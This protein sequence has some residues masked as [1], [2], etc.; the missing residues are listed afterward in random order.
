MD[1]STVIAAQS[2]SNKPQSSSGQ[3]DEDKYYEEHSFD[4]FFGESIPFSKGWKLV[5]SLRPNWIRRFDLV[6]RDA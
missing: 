5:V 2:L 3:F 1:Y 6:P 4:Q